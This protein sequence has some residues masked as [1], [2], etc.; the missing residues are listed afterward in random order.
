MVYKY[1][2]R[3]ERIRADPERI[4]LG[5]FRGCK[6][7]LSQHLEWP[8][9]GEDTQ[10]QSHHFIPKR[11]QSLVTA[12][13]FESTADTSTWLFFFLLLTVACASI[14][15]LVLLMKT[16]DGTDF[17]QKGRPQLVP[18][19]DEQ[20][21]ATLASQELAVSHASSGS[22]AKS[23][24]VVAKMV[25]KWLQENQKSRK[26]IKFQVPEEVRRALVEVHSK[27]N[28][29]ADLNSRE[30][31]RSLSSSLSIPVALHRTSKKERIAV[32]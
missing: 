6:L 29:V 18:P 10:L 24:D 12:D 14:F 20:R 13:E 8:A 2:A 32:K 1:N 21:T 16:G 4:E 26:S 30:S 9:P 22:E 25:P 19:A 23:T 11:I 27:Q 3:F 28:E 7:L 31:E 17:G 5:F 15:M